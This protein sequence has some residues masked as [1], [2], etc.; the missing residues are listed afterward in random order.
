MRIKEKRIQAG[1]TQQGAANRLKINRVSWARYETGIRKPDVNLLPSIAKALGCHI[2]DLFEEMDGYVPEY[3]KEAGG[4]DASGNQV[5]A[6]S[7]EG[8][9]DEARRAVV[10]EAETDDIDELFEL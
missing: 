10:D 8:A 4:E 1:L 5:A 7:D 3:A 6:T 9:V 2:D